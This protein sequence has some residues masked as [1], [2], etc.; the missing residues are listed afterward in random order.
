MPLCHR[1]AVPAAQAKNLKIWQKS[2]ADHL[3]RTQSFSLLKSRNLGT[4]SKPRESERD[5]RI[6]IAQQTRE[7][8]DRQIEQIRQTFADKL[9]TVEDRIRRAELAVVRES[10]E[11]SS[12][13]MDSVISFGT[14]ILGAVLGRKKLSSANL[15]RAASTARGMGRATKQEEDV[16]RA[17]SRLQD[18]ELQLQDLEDEIADETQQIR[19]RFDPLLE[20]LETRATQAPQER[21]RG[22]SCRTRLGPGQIGRPRPSPIARL[23]ALPYAATGLGPVTS[24]G[25]A[26]ATASVATHSGCGL[27]DGTD[28]EAQASRSGLSPAARST[29]KTARSYL[30]TECTHSRP[31][32]RRPDPV[33]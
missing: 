9:R 10:N 23:S 20:E 29:S 28:C 32:R 6:R 31:R 11:A 18:Y 27:H 13:K 8:R 7:E 19:E 2:F 3:Y 22:A 33:E 25:C 21:H 15:G 30:R 5:F 26:R 17:K 16:R 24:A 4:Y 14:T 1:T 12:A